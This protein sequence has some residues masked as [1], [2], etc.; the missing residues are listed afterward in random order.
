MKVVYSYKEG[1]QPLY[2]DNSKGVQ[3]VL[4]VLKH[5]HKT[6]VYY[7]DDY[8]RTMYLNEVI[9]ST[10]YLGFSLEN[11]K[12]IDLDEEYYSVLQFISNNYNYS[13]EHVEE[14]ISGHDQGG[15]VLDLRGL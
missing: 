14:T 5:N 13:G 6:Y 15:A 9:D 12:K 2:V 8:L 10:S 4:I 11:F 7:C 1:M 3:R